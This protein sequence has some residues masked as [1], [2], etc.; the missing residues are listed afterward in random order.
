MPYMEDNM[1]YF[2]IA[3][4][5]PAGVGKST[6]AKKLANEFSF[7][8]IDSGAMYRSVGL[9]CLNNGI[10]LDDTDKIS[11]HLDEIKIDM[12]YKNDIL[13]VYL[14]EEDV[15]LKIRTPEASIAASKVAV[16]KEVRERLVALQR[17]MSLGSSVIMDGRDIGTKVF[18]DADVKIFLTASAE[19]RAERRY[20]ELGGKESYENILKDIKFRD[21]NDSTRK[22]DPLKPA[23]DAI[24]L[25][26][27]A[28]DLEG[29]INEAIKIIRGKINV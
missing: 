1:K 2:K 28:L 6:T 12:S 25:D 3:I 7:T 8:Y 17:E 9:F 14:N 16:I 13:K 26:N 15:S 27:S 23:E 29:T 22:I 19:K 5:G 24:I 21:K 20:K 18:F 4:D 11:A 10:S